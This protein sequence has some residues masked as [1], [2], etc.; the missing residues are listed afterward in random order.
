MLPRELELHIMLT[1]E[2]SLRSEADQSSRKQNLE[3]LI[4]QNYT[5]LQF[6][7]TACF[8]DFVFLVAASDLF[9]WWILC[10]VPTLLRI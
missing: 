4:R 9:L 1:I 7:M 10:I 3:T 5:E 8:T 6:A 2:V